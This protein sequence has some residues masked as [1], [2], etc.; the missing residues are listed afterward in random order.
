MNVRFAEVCREQPLE[1]HGAERFVRDASIVDG[2]SAKELALTCCKDIFIGVFFDGTNNNKF[3]D[4]PGYA[5]SNVARLYEVY[6]G[7]YAEQTPPVLRPALELK[8]DGVLK[9]EPRKVITKEAANEKA[10]PP[11]NFPYYRKIYVPGLGTP[12][13]DVGDTGVGKIQKTGGLSMALL[14]QLRLDWALLQFLNQVHA[15]IFK[16]PIEPSVN[17]K[18]LFKASKPSGPAMDISGVLAQSALAAIQQYLKEQTGTYERDAFD[19]LFNRYMAKLSAAIAQ[20]GDKIPHIRKIRVSVFGFSRGATEARAWINMINQRMSAWACTPLDPDG[21]SLKLCGIPVQIDFLG[22]FDTVASVG[23]CHAVPTFDGHYTWAQSNNLVV[24]AAVKRCVHLVS[25]MEVRGA[26]PLDSVCQSGRLPPNCKEIVYPGVHSDVGGGYPPGDQGRALPADMVG[27]QRKLSQIPLA[28]MYR[29]ALM[30]GVPLAP[31]DKFSDDDKQR[32]AIDPKLREDFNAY[33]EATRV[34]SVQPTLGKGEPQFARLYPTETQPREYLEQIMRRHTGHALRWRKSMLASSGAASTVDISKMSSLSKHQDA[35]DIRGAE[36]ELKREIDFLMSTDPKKFENWDDRT[37]AAIMA[38]S[39]MAAAVASVTLGFLTPVPGATAVGL[40]GAPLSAMFIRKTLADGLNK[41]MK[42]KQQEWDR[43]LKHEWHS[44]EESRPGQR[45][46]I[47]QM[48]SK[49]VH[50]SRA[51]FKLGIPENMNDIAPDDE[52]WFVIGE[53]HKARA[54]KKAALN[55]RLEASHKNNQP[56]TAAKLKEELATLDAR[57]E[58][59]ILGAREPY[60][61]WGYVRMRGLYQAGQLFAHVQDA[62]QKRIDDEE[63]ERRRQQAIDDE[64]ATYKADREKLLKRDAEVRNN[65]E[66]TL[67]QK[68]EFTRSTSSSLTRLDKQH[69]KSLAALSH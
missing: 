32:F 37:L 34:G 12:M 66:R 64:N 42:D 51:W 2:R 23:V 35:E 14:G 58:P 33:V 17:M 20:R 26:F 63:V 22:L 11:E 13:L 30:A 53:L 7:T 27:D 19:A 45:A 29:E 39:P 6:P 21:L 18:S 69:Q 52:E 49:Y 15:A 60:R 9:S 41:A 44:A 16:S 62:T 28:Q 10:V 24:P 3:R 5:Q 55:K 1:L 8:A 36:V 40:A 31:Q 4:I 56:V 61:L 48:M 68:D 57:G 54:A 43:W 50:D 25:A 65:A 59:L 47:A 46:A 67:A 38:A